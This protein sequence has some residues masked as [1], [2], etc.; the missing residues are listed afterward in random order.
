MA[1]AADPET[2]D[3]VVVLCNEIREDGFRCA[4]VDMLMEMADSGELSTVGDVLGGLVDEGRPDWA[5][6]LCRRIMTPSRKEEGDYDYATVAGVIGHLVDTDYIETAFEICK[7]LLI[8][9]DVNGGAVFDC[10]DVSFIIGSMVDIGH[11]EWAGQLCYYMYSGAGN[12]EDNNYET[13]LPFV[14]GTLIDFQ[15]LTWAYEIAQ[16]LLNPGEEF[17]GVDYQTL[18]WALAQTV[19]FGRADWAALICDELLSNKLEWFD[20]KDLMDGVEVCGDSSYS[21][22]ILNFMKKRVLLA[23]VSPV[24]ESSAPLA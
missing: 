20:L 13:L 17:G 10:F 12:N 8:P 6:E 19:W 5:A 18:G 21:Q 4:S 22:T 14:L 16:Q 1:N 15:R 11:P 23:D 2:D 3:F 7:K 9:K 24:G